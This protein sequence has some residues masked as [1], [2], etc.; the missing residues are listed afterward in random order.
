MSAYPEG[1][2]IERGT[3]ML[4]KDMQTFKMEAILGCPNCATPLSLH[5]HEIDDQGMVFPTVGCTA[6][7]CDFDQ[8][9]EL[10]GWNPYARMPVKT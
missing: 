7:Y 9:V 3:W 10:K 8:Y 4:V 5:G 6:Q 1:D 2:K